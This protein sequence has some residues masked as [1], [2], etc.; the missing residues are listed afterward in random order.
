MKSNG[1]LK[2][3]ILISLGLNFALSTIITNNLNFYGRVGGNYSEFRNDITLDK[4][5]LKISKI[6][7]PIHI[8]NNWSAAFAAGI[9]T[10]SGNWSD[11]YV[12]EDLTID[13][14]NSSSCIK[15]ENSN[16]PFI[17]QNCTLLNSSS[18]YYTGGI[19]LVSV[20]N[21]RILFNNCSNNRR[22]GIYLGLSENN[23]V[24]GNLMNYNDGNGVRLRIG[25]VNNT[26]SNNIANN[27]NWRGIVLDESHYNNV[28]NNSAS[29]NSGGLILF[30]CDNNR[31]INNNLTNNIFGLTMAHEF[32]VGCHNNTISKNNIS[33]NTIH[34][35]TI[36]AE[37]ENNTIYDNYF[38]MNGNDN[39]IDVEPNNNWDNGTIGN[40][41]DD[42]SGK[43]IDDDG[44]GDILYIINNSTGTPINQDNYP[45]WWDPPII[46]IHEPNL[47]EIFNE[48]P[49]YTVSIDE[50]I[51]DTMWYTIDDGITKIIFTEMTDT[52][53][54]TEWDKEEEGVVKITFYVN[55]SMGY[56]GFAEIMVV[57]DISSPDITIITPFGNQVFDI[58][59]P[60]YT[61][62]IND[63]SP[64]N[65]TWYTIDN[66]LINYPFF[67]FTGYINQAAWNGIQNGIISLQF[68]AND[69]FG[70]LGFKEIII[71]KDTIVPEIQ[72][73]SP[74]LN[75]IFG[76]TPPTFELSI[77]EANLESTWYT[78]NGGTTNHTFPG[79]IGTINQDAWT[80][81]LE[82][83]ISITFYARD[84]AGYIGTESVTVIKRIPSQSQPAISGYNMYVLLG[85]FSAVAIIFNKKLKKS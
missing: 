85:I 54:Q 38:I 39:A 31:I 4:E 57:K 34:G 60:E 42:Y 10:G 67:G 6:S 14:R 26:I 20:K 63:L 62:T 22:N 33:Y 3:I 23:T 74:N 29:G 50:G 58:F 48:S 84:R 49:S 19:E 79:T 83:E 69:S 72:I 64:I 8:D 56:I 45:I 81:A 75:D 25:C 80:I 5:N 36:T 30:N 40:Y 78:I 13:G 77:T 21:G 44:I 43:D 28:T 35:V 37:S 1:K 18:T 16:V 27:N 41:W 82:G 15:I 9:C 46:S 17:I 12:I 52:T 2:I 68:Y 51:A 76:L 32:L 55:D 61:I 65:S 59:A 73:I 53:N 24:S 71:I 47:N 7:G 70:Y 66:G 11:P